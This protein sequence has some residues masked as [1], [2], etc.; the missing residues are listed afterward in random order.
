MISKKP[1]CVPR[2]TPTLH[3]EGRGWPSMGSHSKILT[4][5]FTFHNNAKWVFFAFSS[6]KSHKINLRK[7]S[8]VC[9]YNTSGHRDWSDACC[10]IV[11]STDS[12]L[13]QCQ[14]FLKLTCRG[15][16]HCDFMSIHKEDINTGWF[17]WRWLCLKLSIQEKSSEYL[18][19]LYL[20]VLTD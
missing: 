12:S 11:S 7:K 14:F 8:H 19:I 9:P 15:D 6:I 18:T 2:L 16:V 20:I 5:K 1:T 13:Q 3:I 10:I 4:Q 17:S